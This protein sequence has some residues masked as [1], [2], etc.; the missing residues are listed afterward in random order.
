MNNLIDY[1]T[2]AFSIS[3][4][5]Y[6][7]LN[8][9]VST[10]NG[11]TWQ[12]KNNDGSL[13]GSGIFM[14]H[15]TDLDRVEGKVTKTPQ[16]ILQMLL[17]D[18]PNNFILTGSYMLACRFEKH[19]IE[20]KDIDIIVMCNDTTTINYLKGLGGLR[21]N[22]SDAMA[23]SSF[24]VTAYGVTIDVFMETPERYEALASRGKH[25]GWLVYAPLDYYL[26]N[27][28]ACNPSK[29]FKHIEMYLELL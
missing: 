9:I 6:L 1:R 28:F 10:D 13:R 18:I 22:R 17:N 5:R 12:F 29:F 24:S 25:D 7:G 19:N 21:E 2:P 27:K 8:Y 26:R 16:F 23:M 4:G 14:F 20:A 11:S 15:K 3:D